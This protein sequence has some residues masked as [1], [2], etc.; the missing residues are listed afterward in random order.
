MLKKHLPDLKRPIYY[1]TGP[2][3]MVGA[4]QK[5]LKSAG[6]KEANIRAEEFSGY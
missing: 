6:V 3:E 5:L 1:L 4:M 2:P